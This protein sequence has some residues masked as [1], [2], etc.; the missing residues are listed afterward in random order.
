M[1]LDH[2]RVVG[3][4]YLRSPRPIVTGLNRSRGYSSKDGFV[5]CW[6]IPGEIQCA[7]GVDTRHRRHLYQKVEDY[8]LGPQ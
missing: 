5:R 3:W 7:A 1:R 4:T 8:L 6:K 2:E